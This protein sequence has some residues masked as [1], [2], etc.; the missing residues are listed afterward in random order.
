MPEQNNNH[1]QLFRHYSVNIA[2]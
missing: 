1:L 2:E